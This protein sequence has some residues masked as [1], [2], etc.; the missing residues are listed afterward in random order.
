[1][2][3]TQAMRDRIRELMPKAWDDY[4]RAVGCVLDDFVTMEARIEALEAALQAITNLSTLSICEDID[5]SR[6]VN[7]IARAALA[8]EQGK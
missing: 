6:R 3:S 5:S 4:D 7:Q 2:K 8:P 1:M